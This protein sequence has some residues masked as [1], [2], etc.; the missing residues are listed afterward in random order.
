MLLYLE[1]ETVKERSGSRKP[2]AKSKNLYLD[3]VKKLVD[4]FTK[5][6][7]KNYIFVDK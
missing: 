5:Y 2:N 3:G 1:R 4:R 6:T 7:E